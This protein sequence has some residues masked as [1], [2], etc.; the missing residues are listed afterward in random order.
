MKIFKCFL[1]LL[2]FFFGALAC[3][4][5]INER[6]FNLLD[7]ENGLG[8]ESVFCIK[9]D[10]RG[11]AL[12]ATNNG[13]SVYD[14][15]RVYS[16]KV[17]R[18]QDLPNYVYD[19]CEDQA[20]NLFISTAQGVFVKKEQDS[21]FRLIMDELVKTET[22]CAHNG[23]L[24]VGNRNGLYVYNGK[25]I[26]Q[27]LIDPHTPSSLANSVRDIKINSKG[28]I[29]FL[30]RYALNR[31][32]PSSGKVVSL[33]VSKD[34]PK[35]IAF[36]HFDLYADKAYIGSKNNGLFV[37]SFKNKEMAKVQEI[38]NVITS[39][40]AT[41]SGEVCVSTD[42]SGAFL[43]DAKSGLVK[44]SFLMGSDEKHVLPSNA[45]YYYMKDKNG[46]NWFGFYR[47]GLGYTYYSLPVFTPYHFGNFTTTQLNV[48][49]FYIGNHIKVIGTDDG[50][51]YIDE[52]KQLLRHFP[53]EMLGGARIIKKIYYHH[54][55]FY[56]ATYD[57]G[58]K[59]LDPSTFTIRKIPN[60]PLLETTTVLSL[61]TAK[62]GNLWIGSAEGVFILD[63][64]GN[65]TR[66]KSKFGGTVSGLYFDDKGN[67]FVCSEQM[68]YFNGKAHAFDYGAFPKGFFNENQGLEAVVGRD[69]KIFFWKQANIYY[70][71]PEMT[72]FGKLQLPSELL[73]ECCYSFGDD[74]KGSYWYVT[75]KGLFRTDYQLNNLLHFSTSEG[76]NC[77]FV[78]VDGVQADDTG[79]IWIGTTQGL[80]K[81]H[82]GVLNQWLKYNKFPLSLY[83]V[84]VGSEI[85]D[86][87]SLD[88]VNV[89]KKLYLDWN[90]FSTKLSIKAVLQDFSQSKGR[91]YQYRIDDGE[92]TSFMDGDEVSFSHLFLGKHQ[93][94]LRV[95]GV[96][97]T[98]TTFDVIVLPSWLAIVE[99][100]VLILALVLW[101]MWHSYHHNTKILL[102]ER[103]EIEGAL[104]EVEQEQQENEQAELHLPKYT[105]VKIDDKECQDIVNRMTQYIEKNH[106]YV[107]PNFKM[108][109]LAEILGLS[110]SKLSQVFSL[111][112]KESYYDF[113]NQYRLGEFKR[114]IAEGEYKRYTLTS[115]SERCGFKKSSFFSTFRKVEGMT[116]ME[117]LKKQNIRL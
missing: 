24:Y 108:S 76:L 17:R 73:N 29:W 37:Y 3:T 7:E 2:G 77:H 83:D 45:V 101:L 114:L 85:L 98:Q 34:L 12:V 88:R 16:F 57:G 64:K 60:A 13:L 28:E 61:A 107:D 14:G 51:Y 65:V 113:I 33:P 106:P 109:D 26:K 42:G 96:P 52:Q 47:F 110:S 56:I 66:I 46:I 67:V 104:I 89:S 105:R 54:G 111:Y 49:A 1:V 31:Y 80:F 69:G 116:P 62:N 99:M 78:N 63:K 117:Y 36:S 72:D 97:S 20:H 44:E 95:A 4:A 91:F 55:L 9:I 59:I 18:N 74:K 48:R 11:R 92:W 87:V 23:L 40:N 84:R 53:L 27:V 93:L 5:E 81:L 6:V 82:P 22:L 25:K 58:L 32:Y 10:S 68:A 100:L 38:S 75:N 43:L 15:K 79:N 102:Q 21:D 86:F 41:D 50:L 70:T 8:G 30:T 103:N 112:M 90:V 19:V 94:R 39:V 35:G 115:L 71:N